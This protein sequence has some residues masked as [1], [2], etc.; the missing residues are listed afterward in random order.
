[1]VPYFRSTHAFMGSKL[2]IIASYVL[3]ILH[4]T[5][6]ICSV[7]QEQMGKEAIDPTGMDLVI[8]QT[9]EPF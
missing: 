4:L 7:T 9:A 5:R 8:I 2:I 6:T 3:P 1:M